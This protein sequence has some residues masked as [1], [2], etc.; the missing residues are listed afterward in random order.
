MVRYALLVCAGVLPLACASSSRQVADPVPLC[1]PIETLAP[2]PERC[3][4]GELDE[5]SQ[6]L[7][8]RLLEPGA[9]AL[10]RVELDDGAR[11]RSVCVGEGPGYG[12]ASAQRAIAK[13]V[14][15]V[16]ALP[17]GPECAA[18]ARL[19]LNRYEA[20]WA[21]VHEREARCQEQTRVTRETHGNTTLRNTTVR[22]HYGVYDREYERCLE[23]DAD[24]IVLDAPGSTRPWIYVKPEVAHPPGPRAYD[25]ASRCTRKSR[26]FEK[27]AACIE[28]DGWERLTPPPR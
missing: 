19:D 28:A 15:A 21:E 23:Y 8:S 18:G 26:V 24:W 4:P 20:K 13:K 7:A 25:T 1:G 22:G 14:D 16:L 6:A 12:P 11:V 27:R 10:V 17:P 2:L 3:E 5:Y 9:S